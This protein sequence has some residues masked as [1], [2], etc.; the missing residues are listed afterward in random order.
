MNR[1]SRLA[2]SLAVLLVGAAEPPRLSDE[3]R[4]VAVQVDELIAARCAAAGVAPAPVA[5]DAEFLRRAFLDLIGTIPTAGETRDFLADP[6]PDK[7]GRLIDG[8]LARPD[9]AT[10][11]AVLWR[12]DLLAT[13]ED[14]DLLPP[15]SVR[16]LDHWLRTRFR[17]NDGYHTLAAGLLTATGAAAA[18]RGAAVYL[19][20]HQAVPE[21]LAAGTSRMFLGVQIDCAQ[22][23]DHPFTKW[24]QKD[25]WGYAAVFA[26]VQTAPDPDG[27]MLPRVED[28]AARPVTVMDTAEVVDARFLGAGQAVNAAV[29]RRS[30]LAEWLTSPSNPYFAPAA[31]NRAWAVLFGYGLVHPID[32]FGDH[33]AASH[34]ELVGLLSRD[35]AG[36]G[37][38][39]RR[40]VRILANTQAYQRTSRGDGEVDPRLFARKAVR[41]LTPRQLHASLR[42]A[43]GLL[44]SPEADPEAREFV[45]RFDS[46]LSRVEYQA[47]IPQALLLM[48]GAVVSA[49]TDPQQSRLISGA[50]DS[51]FFSDNDRIE[52]LFLATL[53]RPPQADEAERTRGYLA[54]AS[55]EREALSDILW[56]LLN[57]PEFA[58]NH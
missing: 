35:F 27:G 46:A 41:P 12:E 50:A 47:G 36:H 54:E 14:R 32:D 58:L 17:E 1:P 3:E 10:H 26:Q 24:G 42:T 55:D 25:F 4:A 38:D 6:S 20:A 15:D 52:V 43:A 18:D 49:L 22:C 57:G 34:P 48:N 31:V 44:P 39:V 45:Q 40:L 30:A 16:L 5:D 9:H 33:N 7:R 37:Y 21:R 13:V 23:H 53:S 8:L 2:A 11:L 19:T 29:S 28:G 51:P 56:A